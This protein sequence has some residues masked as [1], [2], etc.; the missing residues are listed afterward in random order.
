M[1]ALKTGTAATDAVLASSLFSPGSVLTD[2]HPLPRL[3]V[4]DLDYT[5]WPF[6]VDTHTTPPIRPAGEEEK[7]P[8]SRRARYKKEK[9]AAAA[10]DT[11]NDSSFRPVTVIDRY[12]ETFAFYRDVP[13]ILQALPLAGLKMAVASRTSAPELAREMLTLLRVPRAPAKETKDGKAAAG[14]EAATAL[15]VFDAGLEIYPTNKLRHMDALQRRTAIPYEEFLFFDDESRNRN[16]E[17]VGV[18]MFLVRDGVTWD[19]VERGVRAWRRRHGHSGGVRPGAD[20]K[21]G[22]SGKG[23]SDDEKSDYEYSY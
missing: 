8:K 15:G 5:L 4:F 21:D 1:A 7:V 9:E 17:S 18:T 19:A 11:N 16:V 3:V 12:G 10:A 13:R 2:G 22:K 6:W 23:E 20:G 14:K